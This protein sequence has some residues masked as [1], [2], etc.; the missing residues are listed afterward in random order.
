MKVGVRELEVRQVGGGSMKEERGRGEGGGETGVRI[1]V[2]VMEL[3]GRKLG[4]LEEG[5]REE[6]VR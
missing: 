3:E 6:G 1:K 2:G 4:G 5:G